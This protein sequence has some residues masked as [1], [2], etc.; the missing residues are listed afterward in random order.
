L[1]K[2]NEKVEEK[3]KGLQLEIKR[4]SDEM[5][6]ISDNVKEEYEKKLSDL[7]AVLAEKESAY[8]VMQ[9]EFA[10]IKDFRVSVLLCLY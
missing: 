8:R 7:K 4:L 5:K 3:M 2:D 9:Q 6:V 1:H 10:V